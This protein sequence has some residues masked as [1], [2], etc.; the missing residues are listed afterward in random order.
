MKAEGKTYEE[1][2]IAFEKLRNTAGLPQDLK[3]LSCVTT[4]YL[5]EVYQKAFEA[6]PLMGKER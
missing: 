3:W 6:N 1:A 4:S 2:N 5:Y